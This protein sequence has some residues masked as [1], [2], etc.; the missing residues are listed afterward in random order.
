M[1]V[2][3]FSM[4]PM[5][6]PG[7]DGFNARIFQKNWATIDD[8]IFR[9][10]SG[11]FDPGT[12]DEEA[13]RTLLVLLPKVDTPKTLKQFRPISL[14]TV[15]YKVISKFLVNRVKP[16]LP[17]WVGQTQASFVQG[18]HITD[19][20]ILAQ[21]VIHTMCRK[22]GHKAWMAIKVDLE[23]TYD[24]LE[25]TFI[26]ETLHDL[27]TDGFSPSRS[28]RQGDPLS[29]YLFVLCMECLSHAIGRQV[30]TGSW[31]NIHL[32]RSG[33]GL[34]HMFFAN[35]LV[36]FTEASMSQL[37]VIR[38]IMS[39]FCACSG[40][41]RVDDLGIYLGVPL[42]HKRITKDTYRYLLDKSP[43]NNRLDLYSVHPIK[44]ES[45]VTEL[46]PVKE[47]IRSVF[48]GTRAS[49]RR[50]LLWEALRQGINNFVIHVILLCFHISSDEMEVLKS[51]FGS[52]MRSW[53]PLFPQKAPLLS[54]RSSIASAMLVM[55]L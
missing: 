43:R 30:D 15:M 36:L 29:A 13:N 51:M 38:E 46:P 9:F 4:D 50:S 48:S 42:L 37:E 54:Q 5:K 23:K 25:C 2:V 16:Y 32:S 39:N 53:V 40:H 31:K 34:L 12:L 11:F 21:E 33:P 27:V 47:R 19:N 28:V 1:H 10:V 14:C 49:R 35:D 8:S 45:K 22:K 20:V 55:T 3:V 18:R 26:E 44:L 52:L 6:S 17:A 41:R 24:R 7:V